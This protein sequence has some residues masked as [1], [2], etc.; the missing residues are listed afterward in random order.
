MQEKRF[1]QP[2]PDP[3]KLPHNLILEDRR[4][5]TITG[6]ADIDSFDEQT[7]VLFTDVGE[8]TV[9]GANLHINKLSVE[10]GEVSIE[11]EVGLL[12]YADGRRGKLAF[13]H[14]LRAERSQ[15]ATE[16][17]KQEKRYFLIHRNS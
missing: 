8:L 14:H 12:A 15:H 10:T 16:G 6:V 11:G 3:V 9:K 4:L 1:E 5:L 13:H 2:A 7:V 17:K